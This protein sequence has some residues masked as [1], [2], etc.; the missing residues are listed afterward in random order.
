MVK[1]GAI[2]EMEGKFEHILAV[3]KEMKQGQ[4]DMQANILNVISTKVY[5]IVEVELSLVLV[6]LTSRFEATR[7]L[8][9]DGPCN[10]EPRSDVEDDT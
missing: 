4:E 8:F 6:I 2:T 1:T 5:A 7:R 9:W 3:I 10:F